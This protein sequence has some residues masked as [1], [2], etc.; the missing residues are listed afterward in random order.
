MESTIEEKLSSFK[1]IS[2]ASLAT[3]VPA[4]PIAIPMFA[5]DKAGASLSP[6]PVIATTWPIDCSLVTIRNFWSGVTREN[7]TTLSSLASNSSS[8]NS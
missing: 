7:I 4:I 2:A 8:V 1:T 3:S 5:R 6:S